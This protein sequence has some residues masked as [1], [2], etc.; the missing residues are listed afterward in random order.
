MHEASLVLAFLVD[1]YEL[2]LADPA[3]EV[4]YEVGLTMTAKDGVWLRLVRA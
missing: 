4:T 3:R 2:A 1:R